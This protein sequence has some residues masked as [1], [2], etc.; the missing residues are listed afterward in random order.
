MYQSY[1][2]EKELERETREVN[3][4]FLTEVFVWYSPTVEKKDGY[5]IYLTKTGK[6]LKGTTHTDKWG[7]PYPKELKD[8][9]IM[10]RAVALK[11]AV[12]IPKV[13]SRSH[14]NALPEGLTIEKTCMCDLISLSSLLFEELLSFSGMAHED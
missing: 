7:N 12:D 10:G 11:E 4:T 1:P 6:L 5:G 3:H 14:K 2:T 8:V 13:S 9:E